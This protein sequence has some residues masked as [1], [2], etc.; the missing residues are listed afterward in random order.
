MT[1]VIQ[2]CWCQGG[3]ECM[4]PN[5]K[6]FLRIDSETCKCDFYVE[7]FSDVIKIQLAKKLSDWMARGADYTSEYQCPRRHTFHFREVQMHNAGEWGLVRKL[8]FSAKAVYHVSMAFF[9]EYG[10]WVLR[11][12][13]F[14][15]QSTQNEIRT[16]DVGERL[17][18]LFLEYHDLPY[19]GEHYA[20]NTIEVRLWNWIL[21]R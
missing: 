21:R 9:L 5:G 19:N 7:H 10:A 17:R 1:T 4:P 14:I 16:H 2:K 11:E 13:N 12:G 8:W 15:E 6:G 3:H 18:N 20:L